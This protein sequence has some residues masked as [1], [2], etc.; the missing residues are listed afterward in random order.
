MCFCLKEN[1]IYFNP[2]VCLIFFVRHLGIKAFISTN[3]RGK[4]VLNNFKTH[5][6][7]GKIF[8]LT[9]ICLIVIFSN[10]L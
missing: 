5:R 2:E 6:K 10:I 3:F 1:R 4:A 8:L 9:E 7:K